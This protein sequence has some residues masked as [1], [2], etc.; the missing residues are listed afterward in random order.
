MALTCPI[1]ACIR[2]VVVPKGAGYYKT[3]F[4]EC[5]SCSVMFR[6]P[7]KFSVDRDKRA[8]RELAERVH[9]AE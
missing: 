6:D 2:E 5:C 3:A 4:F 8:K 1:C 7:A 9:R